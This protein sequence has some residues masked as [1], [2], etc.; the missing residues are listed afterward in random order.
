[1]EIQKLAKKASAYYE[2]QDYK[3]AIATFA[4]LSEIDASYYGSAKYEDSHFKLVE[5]Y[6]LSGVKYFNEGKLEQSVKEF[7]AA[8]EM[9]ESLK[10][11]H[12]K[13]DTQNYSK[14]IDICK[15]NKSRMLGKIQKIKE[16]FKLAAECNIEGVKFFN[17]GSFHS[18][19]YKFESAVNHLTDIRVLVPGYSVSDYEGL[20]QVY[21]QN[22]KNTELKLK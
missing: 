22:L 14:W 3:K 8:I 4:E 5:K 10:K 6:N 20:M 7:E 19:K 21:L 13:Y 12:V 1:M 15:G 11:R 17:Q 2:Q 18:A 16:S 9:L